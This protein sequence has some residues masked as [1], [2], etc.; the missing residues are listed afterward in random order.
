MTSL[1][2]FLGI[3]IALGG[4]GLIAAP[5][6]LLGLLRNHEQSLVLYALAIIVRALFGVALLVVAPDSLF[7]LALK[8]LGWLAIGAAIFIAA[9]GPS[10]FAKLMTNVLRWPDGWVRVTGAITVLLGGFLVYAVQ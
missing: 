2:F 10:R 4:V 1:I 6:A 8:A 5:A 3:V 9:I 7:P